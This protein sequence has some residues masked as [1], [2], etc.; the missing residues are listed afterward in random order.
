MSDLPPVPEPP[1]GFDSWKEVDHPGPPKPPPP[2]FRVAETSAVRGG[3]TYPGRP[4]PGSLGDYSIVTA[5]KIDT[6]SIIDK[7]LT[8]SDEG[9]VVD[10]ISFEIDYRSTGVSIDSLLLLIRRTLIDLEYSAA[11]AANLS[12][13]VERDKEAFCAAAEEDEDADWHREKMKDA[14][15]VRTE[16]LRREE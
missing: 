8:A 5:D 7:P 14:L 3:M 15:I 2:T 16:I 12:I 1:V 9:V 6:G 4:Y 10:S 11:E 13:A